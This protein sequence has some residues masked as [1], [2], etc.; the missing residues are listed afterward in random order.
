[1]PDPAPENL[2]TGS[3]SEVIEPST[4][5]AEAP[6]TAPSVITDPTPE[7]VAPQTWSDDWRNQITGIPVSDSYTA[8]Q[9]KELTIAGRF[10]APTDVYKS[11][12]EGQKFASSH[13]APLEKPV[14]DSTPEQLEAYRKENGIPTEAKDYDLTFD[15]GTVLGEDIKPQIDGYLTWAHENHLSSDEVKS[16]VQW[17]LNDVQEHQEAMAMAND[18]ARVDGLSTLKSEWGAE[19]QGNLNAIQSLFTSAPEGTMDALMS[20]AGEDG[21]KFANNADNI[22]WLV[23]LAKQINPTATLVPPGPNHD[24]GIDAE[25][26]K[27]EGYMNSSDKSEKDKYWKD[28]KTQQRYMKLIQARE[29]RG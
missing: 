13:K 27:I 8:D 16:N 2:S 24:A 28:D 5:V 7:V 21:L 6:V 25:I 3:A 12:R 18:Q 4:I 11:M 23:S 1:M 14:E 19:F 10:G 17:Y 22:K 9:Q 26:E 15:D 20:A 29:N